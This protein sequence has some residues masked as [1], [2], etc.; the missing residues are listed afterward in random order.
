MKSE[1]LIIS[2]KELANDLN[3]STSFIYDN[4]NKIQDRVIYSKKNSNGKYVIIRNPFDKH[5]SNYTKS[6]QLA[7]STVQELKQLQVKSKQI[8]KNYNRLMHSGLT[9]MMSKQDFD[10]NSQFFTE[11]EQRIANCQKKLQLLENRSNLLSDFLSQCSKADIIKSVERSCP[12]K[13]SNSKKPS[14]YVVL[15]TSNSVDKIRVINALSGLKFG[16]LNKDFLE[17]SEISI[18]FSDHPPIY[19]R[20]CFSKKRN[21]IA[22]DEYVNDITVFFDDTEYI[23]C[24]IDLV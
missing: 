7:E 18:R 16:I 1:N 14:V 9:S 19:F 20:E 22:S 11:I 10:D 12:G 17:K 8:F 13:F 2:A 15:D 23:D 4:I 5:M 24:K 21:I 3:K 6:I